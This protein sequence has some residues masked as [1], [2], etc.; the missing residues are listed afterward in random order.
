M[1]QTPVQ[2]APEL[3][4]QMKDEQPVALSYLLALEELPFNEYERELIFYI[5]LVVWQIMRQSDQQLYKVTRK[6]MECDGGE[7]HSQ[8]QHASRQALRS[9]HT[10]HRARRS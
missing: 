9:R 4:E 3:V 7:N 1:C 6:K 8:S 2:R 10:D 5:G